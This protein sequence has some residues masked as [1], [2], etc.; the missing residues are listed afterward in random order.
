MLEIGSILTILE[1][2]DKEVDY[3]VLD[4]I[5][6]DDQ[7][8]MVL[9]NAE[10]ELDEVLILELIESDEE[11]VSYGEVED[12]E[13]LDE[14]FHIFEENM[15]DFFDDDDEDYLDDEEDDEDEEI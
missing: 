11:S 14:I 6:L 4:I 12:E 10:E 2:E 1:E 9:T 15:E 8:F 3:E 13:L 7:S 5:D